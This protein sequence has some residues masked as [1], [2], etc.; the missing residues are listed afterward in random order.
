MTNDEGKEAFSDG[1][2]TQSFGS[3]RRLR[4]AFGATGLLDLEIVRH[5]D[6][7]GLE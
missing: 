3:A 2:R 7:I 4:I 6:P 5:V 1:F